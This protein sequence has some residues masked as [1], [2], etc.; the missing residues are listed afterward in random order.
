MVG[1][2]CNTKKIVVTFYHYLPIILP[3]FF[4]NN[5]GKILPKSM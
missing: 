4:L 5:S 3:L 2:Q 1:I